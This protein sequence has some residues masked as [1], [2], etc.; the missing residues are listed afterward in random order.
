[1][2]QTNIT[3]Y[4]VRASSNFIE[5]VSYLRLSHVTVGYNFKRLI[6]KQSIIKDLNLSVTGR[7]LFLLTNYSGSDPQVNF[8]SSGGVGSMGIDNMNVP[9]TR[10]FN[11]TL[12]ATF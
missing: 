6:S 10:S 7:N 5:D 9:N 11:I 12:N 1:M 2:N 3:E 8:D 4:F